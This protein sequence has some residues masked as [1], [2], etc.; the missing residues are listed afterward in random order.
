MEAAIPLRRLGSIKNVV[1]AAVFSASDQAA[2]MTGQ[3]LPVD[4]RQPI[5]ESPE[6]L[7]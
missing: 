5:P 2:F 4:D 7:V 6:V 3:M 1:S